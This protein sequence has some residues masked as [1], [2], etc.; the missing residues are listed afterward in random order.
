MATKLA[1]THRIARLL[2]LATIA[3]AMQKAAFRPLQLPPSVPVPLGAVDHTGD[4]G[5]LCSR[6]LHTMPLKQQA[7]SLLET[8]L[9][10][11]A[12]LSEAAADVEYVSSCFETGLLREGMYNVHHNE[13]P[14]HLVGLA[15]AG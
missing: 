10:V 2:S 9:V 13:H 15:A 11:D 5:D 8:K 1:T 4:P 14:A 6:S 12:E 3:T 7:V